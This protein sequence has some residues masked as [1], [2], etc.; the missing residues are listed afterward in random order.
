MAAPRDANAMLRE[1]QENDV[2]VRGI[3]LPS[4]VRVRLVKSKKSPIWREIKWV[5]AEKAVVIGRRVGRD[6]DGRYIRVRPTFSFKKRSLTAA[7]VEAIASSIVD[8]SRALEEPL[9]D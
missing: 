4:G 5:V 1:S 9:Y 3:E 2:A 7:E 8:V 6:K